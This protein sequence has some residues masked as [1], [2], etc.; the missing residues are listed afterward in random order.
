MDFFIGSCT[1][2]IVW[3]IIYTIL[4]GIKEIVHTAIEK[5]FQEKNKCEKDISR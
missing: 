5:Y 3:L 2:I 4:A 1:A